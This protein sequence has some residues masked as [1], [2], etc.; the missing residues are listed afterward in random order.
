MD[1][2]R[3]IFPIAFG[4][5]PKETPT[6]VKSII[7]HVVI[8]VAWSVVAFILGWI[9]GAVMGNAAKIITI[10]IDIVGYAVSLYSTGGVVLSILKFVNVIKN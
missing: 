9:L 2:L 7:I 5:V 3:K 6:L 10:P 1:F 8:G 4:V